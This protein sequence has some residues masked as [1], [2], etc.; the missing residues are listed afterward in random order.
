ME[1]L[2][3]TIAGLSG[4]AWLTLAV[5]GAAT[6]TMARERLS[7]DV[8][9]FGALCVLVVA[10]VLTPPQ[11]LRGFSHPAIFTIGV[12]LVV[13]G[14]VQETGALRLVQGSLFGRRAQPGSVLLRLML[15]TAALSAFLNN[16]PIVAM[17]IP[18]V[19]SHAKSIGLPPS[20]LLL[21][22]AWAAMFGGTCTMIGTSAN[23][24]V[25]GMLAEQGIDSVGI[26]DI[27]LVGIPT[28]IVG[29]VYL[30]TVGYR[31]IPDRTAALS[32]ARAEVRDYLVELQVAPDSPLVGATVEDA[33]L[34][35][36][37]GLFLARIRQPDGT[38]LTAFAPS[39][40][41]HAG[42][43]LV[44]TGVATTVQ[45]LLSQ[46]PGL[47]PVD[48]PVQLFEQELYE[49]VISHRSPLVGLTVRDADFRR[50]FNA[51]IIAVHRQ[52]A[53][54][55]Q[56]IGDIVLEPG[57]TLMLWASA[58][59]GRNHR[60]SPVFYLI[61]ALGEAGTPRFAKARFVV[62]T[63]GVMV[64]VPAFT[65]VPLLVTGMGALV[66]LFVGNCLTVRTARS[67]VNGPVLVMIGSAIGL[68]S[69]LEHSGAAEAL[70]T[71]L[72][73]LTAPLG[74]WGTLAAVY[75]L[76]VTLAAFVSN[77]AGAA[78][79]LPVALEAASIGGHS[80]VPFAIAIAMAAS[81]GFSTPIG[82]PPNLLVYGPGGY[83]YLDFARV[84]LPL[85][86][87]FLVVTVVLVPIWWPFG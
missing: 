73:T 82:C 76:G 63:M 28:T 31:L 9:L 7:P 64:L 3:E 22:L 38:L 4:G 81:A 71:I 85:N 20:K 83:R 14:A 53:R 43:L 12:L 32:T 8:V 70:A 86:V 24:V 39:Y 15:P 21:P 51:A 25:Q 55:D 45:D 41:L 87:L 35:S 68:A 58:G 52:G 59:F 57:D 23:L 17:L 40:R 6:L 33:G 62:A 66:V 5:V 29:I 69:A 36:L 72:L 37:P 34:R 2:F 49:V 19:R 44:F 18:V 10:G 11:A 61:G 47:K 80:P 77:A 67:S 42:D 30:V 27:A 74:P 50:R 46:V 75:V 16:T 84:G 56:K 78:L 1:L 13:A 48:E 60:S 54:I 26:F 65:D 79:V